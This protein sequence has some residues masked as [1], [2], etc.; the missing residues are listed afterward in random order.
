MNPAA[1]VQVAVIL[2]T[3]V[4]PALAVALVWAI[5][6]AAARMRAGRPLRMPAGLAAAVGFFAAM[7][8]LRGVPVWPPTDTLDYLAPAVVLAALLGTVADLASL[9]RLEWLFWVLAAGLGTATAWLLLVPTGATGGIRTA[10]SGVGAFSVLA[11]GTGWVRRIPSIAW[12]AAWAAASAGAG[13]GLALGGSA[14]LGQA[15]AGLATVAFV[16]GLF[17]I[18]T[19]EKPG[20]SARWTFVVAYGGLLSY[21]HAFSEVPLGPL[22]TFLAAPLGVLAGLPARRSWL[23]ALLAAVAA[24][25]IGTAGIVWIR[26]SIGD[27]YLG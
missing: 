9:K 23:S 25:A 16:S 7:V 15:F 8:G 5:A 4:W 17:S 6:F 21:S 3:A 19:R 22:A 2:K 13:A 12:Y 10:V 14:L 18:R 26:H 24:L 20:L 27:A 11:T 1:S